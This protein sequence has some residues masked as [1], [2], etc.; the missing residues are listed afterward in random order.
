MTCTCAKGGNGRL[1]QR[2]PFRGRHGTRA[3]PCRYACRPL[4]MPPECKYSTYTRAWANGF[5][6]RKVAFHAQEK[7]NGGRGYPQSK[8]SSS[9][10]R[11]ADE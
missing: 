3:L 2:G 1:S 9:P 5:P 8:W 7:S 6:F 4:L 11:V 10:S